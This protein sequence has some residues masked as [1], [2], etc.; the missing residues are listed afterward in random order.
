[1]KTRC[2]LHGRVFVMIYMYLIHV[3]LLFN[4]SY[5]IGGMLCPPKIPN[6]EFSDYPERLKDY[7][8]NREYRRYRCREGYRYNR[9]VPFIECVAGNWTTWNERFGIDTNDLCLPIN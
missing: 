9:G 3:I 6:G 1:M 5:F 7:G 4:N 2:I 8:R